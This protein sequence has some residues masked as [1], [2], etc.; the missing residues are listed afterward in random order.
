MHDI[1]CGFGEQLVQILGKNAGIFD[2]A[3]ADLDLIIS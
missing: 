3:A 1:Y 2:D